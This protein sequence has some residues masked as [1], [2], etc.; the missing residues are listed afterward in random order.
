MAKKPLLVFPTPAIA[1]RTKKSGQSTETHFPS[2]NRQVTKYEDKISELDRVLANKSAALQQQVGSIIPEMLLV[3]ETAGE[4][5]DFFKAVKKTPGMEFLAENQ[6]ETESDEDFYHLDKAGNRVDKSIDT[7]FYLT[8]TNQRALQELQKYW[9]E[10]KKDKE[11]QNFEKGTTKFRHLFDQLKDIR[12]YS[13]EDRTRDTGIDDYISEM[14]SYDH[15]LVKFEIELAFK[16]D[17]EQS[18]ASYNEVVRLLQH[19][20]GQAIAKS[21]TV[22]PEVAYHAFIAEAPV[23]AFDD[24]SESTDILF[25]KSQQI[26]FFRP[27]GQMILGPPE[28]TEGQPIVEADEIPEVLESPVVAV[29]DG[30][31]LENHMLLQNRIVVDDPDGFSENYLGSKRYHGTAMTSL[32]IHGDLD[33]SPSTPLG[34]PIYVRPIMKP[35]ANTFDNGEFLPDDRLPIDIVHRAV[36]RMKVGEGATPPTAPDVKIINFSIG[37]A[38]RPFI[39]NISS[40]ARLLDWLAHEYNLLFIVSAGNYAENITLQVPADE[41]NNLTED[42][43]QELT[44]QH[45]V[46]TNFNRKILTPAESINALTVGSSHNDYA[47]VDDFY[48]RKNLIKSTEL[49]SPV[50]RI[51]FGYRRGIKPEILMPGGRKLYRR[52]PIQP[53]RHQMTLSPERLSIS[54]NPPG[55]RAAVPGS[56]GNNSM[57]AYLCGTSN[58]AALTTRLAAQLHDVL[59]ALNQE[60]GNTPINPDYF[61][62]IIKSLLVHG[63]SWS[64]ESALLQE[65][66]SRLAGTASNTSKKNLLPYLGYGCVNAERILYCTDQRATLLGY[67]ELLNGQAHLY[68]F[69]LPPSLGQRKIDKRLTITLAYLSPLNFKTRKY[70]KAQLFYDNVASDSLIALVRSSYDFRT[71]QLGTVQHDVLTG[72][73]ADV[74]VDGDF[75]KVKV[76]CREDAS[77]LNIPIRYGLSVILEV[78]EGIDLPIYGEIRQ[79]IQQRIRP[80]I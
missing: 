9:R 13:V 56:E 33:Q 65:M 15:D 70:R 76:N 7:R 12:P 79:R 39:D 26:L 38:F 18:Q 59:V 74:F 28:L 2:K 71:A 77:G 45:I 17:S 6:S 25:L 36:V 61:T 8:M 60:E 73:K 67:G 3:L 58:A 50:S 55:N 24:L 64:N 75:L 57:T 1:D 46:E 23:Q 20:G 41:F 42:Q 14:K 40:W 22:I 48:Q 66:V 44:L 37:D 49:L 19:Q 32:I 72:D 34:R 69:P 31:P 27:V 54:G 4:I 21:R 16:N 62:V 11:Q 78:E 30:L 43:V 47:E 29:L 80:S 5:S 10:Y 51:G 68:N 52:V 35:A 63:A 53:D